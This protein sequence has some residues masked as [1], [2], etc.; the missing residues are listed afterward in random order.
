MRSHRRVSAVIAMLAAAVVLLMPVA[1]H[2][3]PQPGSV[4]ATFT[5]LC[6][7]VQADFT[8]S[9]PDVS[10]AAFIRFSRNG[11]VLDSFGAQVNGGESTA[12][13]QVAAGGDLIH[14]EWDV[15][16]GT[17]ESLD[18]LHVTPPSCAEPRVSVS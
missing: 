4:T 14:Y 12:L 2:A 16:G 1:A 10:D 11:K 18:Y 6:G 13:Y 7:F 9:D 15:Q 17:T 8:N 3:E 5:D